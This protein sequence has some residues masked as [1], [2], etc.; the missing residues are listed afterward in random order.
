MAVDSDRFVLKA[1]IE[2]YRNLL[3]MDLAPATRGTVL[4]LLSEVEEELRALDRPS[5]TGGWGGCVIALCCLTT[6]LAQAA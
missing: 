6:L 1:N 2:K 3:N 5:K 4:N